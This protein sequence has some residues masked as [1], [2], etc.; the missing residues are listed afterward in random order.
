MHRCILILIAVLPFGIAAADTTAFFNVNVIPMSDE[1]IIR[2]QT[3]IVSDG[4][5]ARVGDVDEVPVPEGASVV[6]G[7]DRFLIPGLAEM[8]AHLP[9]VASA[10]LD[11]D[12]ALF[13]ANGVTT[14]RGMLGHPSHL[15]LRSDLLAGKRVGPRLI[16]SGPSLNGRSVTSPADG[17]T[18]G[19]SAARGGLRLHQDPP[20]AQRR[21]IRGDSR[22]R[23]WTGHALCRPRAGLGRPRRCAGGGHGQHRSSRRLHGG[24]DAAELRHVRRL[25][26]LLR[27]TA[28]GRRRQR[29]D[30]GPCRGDGA[31]RN[32]ERADGNP[33][34]AAY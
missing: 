23:E 19:K 15:Q 18:P 28:G 32:L 3:V 22:N 4:V 9:P 17:E 25:R 7:T 8:H 13:I 20:G 31:G 30:T 26:R 14:V 27:R 11:R 24:I 10:D 12:L 33:G 29:R 1:R 34:G 2:Q 6:D 16:T 21:G 5:I